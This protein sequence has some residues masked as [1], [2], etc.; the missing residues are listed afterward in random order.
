MS[1]ISTAASSKLKTCNIVS[2]W[3]SSSMEAITEASSGGL[4]WLQTAIYTDRDYLL[5]LVRQAEQ[6]GFKALVL[7]VDTPVLG[8]RVASIRNKFSPPGEK[9]FAMFKD[10]TIEANT[11]EECSSSSFFQYTSKLINPKQSWQDLDW[12]RSCTKLPIILKG[13]LTGSDAEEALKHDI[14]GIM[15][16]NHGGRQLDGVPATVR[17]SSMY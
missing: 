16:S 11:S 6:L 2:N 8:K 5:K 17:D 15:V 12:L 10:M 1:V 13:I 4:L 14:Q 3:S 7:T 9:A